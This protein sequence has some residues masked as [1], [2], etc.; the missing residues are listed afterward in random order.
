MPEFQRKREVDKPRMAIF[1]RWRVSCS[2]PTLDSQQRVI[3]TLAVVKV[4]AEEGRRMGHAQAKRL[5]GQQRQMV[6]P[7]MAKRGAKSWKT[8]V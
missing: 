4:L 7:G 3:R 8:L 5:A 2:R 6:L 1:L